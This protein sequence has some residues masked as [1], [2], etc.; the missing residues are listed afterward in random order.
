VLHP[1]FEECSGRPD[2]FADSEPEGDGDPFGVE[3]RRVGDL[4]IAVSGGEF[5]GRSEFALRGC[6]DVDR[7]PRRL[8]ASESEK[9]PFRISSRVK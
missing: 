5:T 1:F 4:D 8:L 6:T 7:P 2:V 9:A 3:G